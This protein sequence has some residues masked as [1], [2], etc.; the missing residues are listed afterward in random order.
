MDCRIFKAL[1][2]AAICCGAMDMAYADM[3]APSD[4]LAERKSNSPREAG[5]TGQDSAG[6]S[7]GTIA[8]AV[9]QNAIGPS[10]GGRCPMIPSCSNYS[11]V[12]IQ[13][14]GL[15]RGILASG[16]RLHRCGHDLSFYQ[17]IVTNL[18]VYYEDPP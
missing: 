9:Y 5:P 14:Y 18:G 12:A 7:T 3:R 15:I 17:A 11:R 16:D 1:L 4:H 10:K 2:I 8:I 6:V 13:K